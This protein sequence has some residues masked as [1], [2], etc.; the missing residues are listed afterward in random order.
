LSNPPQFF[1]ST[2]PGAT[3]EYTLYHADAPRISS[4]DPPAN[5]ILTNL[6]SLQVLFTKPVTN[7]DAA[8][9]LIHGAPATGLSGADQIMPSPL[10]CQPMAP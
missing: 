2:A 8:D 9:L 4:Q 3:F 6:T 1:D 10:R 7:V 5:A